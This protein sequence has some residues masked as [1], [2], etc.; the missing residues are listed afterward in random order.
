MAQ[1]SVGGL[2]HSGLLINNPAIIHI[3]I[4][5]RTDESHLALPQELTQDM[6][7][8]LRR[9]LSSLYLSPLFRTGSVEGI[10][11]TI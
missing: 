4:S 1:E 11:L 3:G 6:G 7:T 9:P 2:R 5:P 10:S 8:F